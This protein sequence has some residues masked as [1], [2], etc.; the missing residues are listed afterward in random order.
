MK[1]SSSDSPVIGPR[2]TLAFVVLIALIA[3]G[4]GLVIWQFQSA[5]LQ[6]NRLAGAQQQL[7]AAFQLQVSVL[8]LH[9]T[10]RDLLESADARRLSAETAPLRTALSDEG[11]RI[12]TA[13]AS[14]RANT[15]LEPALLPLME[16][17]QATLPAQ[18]EAINDLTMTG[19]WATL[20]R[21]LQ[22]ELPPLEGQTSELVNRI[23]QRARDE[24]GQAMARM[25][26]V[27]NS[28]LV[29]VPATAVASFVVAAVLGWSVLRR[30]VELR[31]EA[32][33]AERTRI[34]RDLHDTLLQSFHGVLLRFQAA[35]IVL[36]DRPMD[37]KQQLEHAI[38]EAAQAITEGRNA[39]QNLR[40]AT[41]AADDLAVAIGTLGRELAATQAT[42]RTATPPVID[43]SVEG[44]P[45]DL[46]PIVRDEVYRIA[47]EAVRN[48]FRHASAHRIE[49][50]IRYDERRLRVRVRD[51][52]QGIQPAVLEGDRPGHF[53]LPGMRERAGVIGGR[54]D[55]WSEAGLGTEIELT[56][57]AA[58]AYVRSRRRSSLFGGRTGTYS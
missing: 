22:Y 3:V 18:L 23:D 12:R 44:T 36:Q 27:Q 4:N 34:A 8:S 2:L 56:V 43:V 37:A 6:T 52:G 16:S 21:R 7:I 11:V 38:D 32:R 25:R 5:R 9:Q 26:R 58:A 40:S 50:D 54:L 57:P 55:V 17:I 1:P 15:P 51:D 31:L 45:R 39:V 48:A 13:L 41:A 19:D 14:L 53:G 35:T 30:I 20:Q 42:D 49:V 33:V 28:I 47:G 29:I 10:L 46:H 24:L